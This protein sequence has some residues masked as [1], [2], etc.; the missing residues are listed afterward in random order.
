MEAFRRLDAVAAP[1]RRASV[2]TDQIIPMRYL[3]TASRAALGV[4]LFAD[5]RYRQDGREDPSFVLNQP[6]YRAAQILVADA[7]FGCGSSREHAPWALLDYGIRAL[8]APSFAGIFFDNAFKN[9]ILLIELAVEDVA[10][11]MDLLERGEPRLDVDLEAQSVTARD[12][13]VR[14]FR[15]DARRRDA[16]LQGLDEIGMSLRMQPAIAAYQ[17]ADRERRP[18]I[19]R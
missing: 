11:L 13:S 7:N 15:V 14:P 18:W 12:G 2:D 16:L 3:I 9:G 5:W 8:I 4:G 19:Y 17:A 6:R 1:L 10:A